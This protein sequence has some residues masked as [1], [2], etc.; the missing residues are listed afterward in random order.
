MSKALLLQIGLFCRC[1]RV[2][3][4]PLFLCHAGEYLLV[5]IQNPSSNLDALS[6]VDG[7]ARRDFLAPDRSIA[8]VLHLLGTGPGGQILM[9]LGHGPL[10]TKQL[11][12]RVGQFSARSIYRCVGKMQSHGLI[13]RYE[14]PGPPSKVLLRLTE[15]GGRNLFRLVRAF[16]VDSWGETCLLGDLWEN[17]FVEQLSRGPK[18]LMDLLESPHHLTYHQVKRRANMAVE[19]GLLQGSI[20]KGNSRRYELTDQG[21]RSLGLIAGIGRWQHRYIAPGEAPGLEMEEM[22]TVLRGVMPLSV[23]TAHIG[24]R[25]DLIVAGAEEY[26]YRATATVPGTV[27]LE[28]TAHFDPQSEREADGSAAATINTWFAALLDGNRGRLR[29]RGDL[30]LVDSCVKQLHEALWETSTR[31]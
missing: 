8:G 13:D 11:T 3:E 30:G 2:T 21:R 16:S 14:E 18:S 10:R 6:R 20:C 1:C 17:G 4:K 28:G 25:I 23:L 12:E 27:G 24:R 7:E 5:P 26:G 19:C 15:R 9:E 22:A 31:A 29:V